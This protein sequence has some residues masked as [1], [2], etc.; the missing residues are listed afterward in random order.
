VF[1]AVLRN[2]QNGAILKGAINKGAF[3]WMRFG[4]YRSRLLWQSFSE[5]FVRL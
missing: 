1:G 5:L 3:L 4:S 2:P